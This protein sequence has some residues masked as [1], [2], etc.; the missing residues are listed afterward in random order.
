MDKNLKR[1]RLNGTHRWTE[2]ETLVLVQEVV[3]EVKDK[4]ESFE[5][6]NV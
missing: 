1:R 4:P 6:F 3:E 2:V 5:V